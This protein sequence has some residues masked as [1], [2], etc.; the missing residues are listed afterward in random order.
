VSDPQVDLFNVQGLR[1]V[2]DNDSVQLAERGAAF[3]VLTS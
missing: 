2:E 3:E 1:Y